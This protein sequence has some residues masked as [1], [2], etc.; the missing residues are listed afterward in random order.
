MAL[1][2]IMVLCLLVYRIGEYRLRIR[3]TEAEQFIPDPGAQ[4]HSTPDHAA[5]V[6]QCFE[7]I[8]FLHVQTTTTS[9]SIVLRLEP[10]HRLILALL[11]PLYEKFYNPSG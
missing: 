6:F 3:L 1:S 7:G 9:L 4:T 10:V 2:L 11:G 5:L 8:E